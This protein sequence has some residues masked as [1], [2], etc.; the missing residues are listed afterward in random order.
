MFSEE[1]VRRIKKRCRA[2]PEQDG[3]RVSYLKALI[4]LE[5]VNT[6]VVEKKRIFRSKT[7]M[8]RL[9]GRALYTFIVCK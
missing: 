2:F 5:Q 1:C 9:T 6:S 7:S 8:V 4:T 3:P